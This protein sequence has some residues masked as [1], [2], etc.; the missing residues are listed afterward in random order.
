MVVQFSKYELFEQKLACAKATAREYQMKTSA[1][2][3]E[4]KMTDIEELILTC[5]EFQFDIFQPQLNL[6]CCSH[7]R[8][9]A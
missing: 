3:K 9:M 4:P 5:Q 1:A 6:H 8:G 7:I 2:M